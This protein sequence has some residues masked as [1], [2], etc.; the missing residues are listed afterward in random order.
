LLVGER[1]RIDEQPGDSDERV[2]IID[3]AGKQVDRLRGRG[4]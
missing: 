4:R 3:C 1:L 2:D